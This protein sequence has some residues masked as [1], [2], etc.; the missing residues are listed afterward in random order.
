MK[1]V[2][3]FIICIVF[4]A[5]ALAG[6]S[7]GMNVQDARK[8]VVRVVQMA[9]IDGYLLENGVPVGKSIGTI[10]ESSVVSFGTGFGV[11]KAGE[12][13]QY[14]ATNQHVVQENKI[15][16][17]G[18]LKDGTPICGVTVRTG[19]YLLLDDHS[20]DSENGLDTS[21]AVPCDVIYEA[22]E[23]E[24]DLA[25]LKASEPVEQRIALP[26]LD[27]AAI[28]QGTEVRALG[29]PG[30]SDNFTAY[31]YERQINKLPSSLD[32]MTVTNGAV[33]KIAYVE[34]LN[35][36]LIQSTAQ[37]NHGNSGGPLITTDGAVIG[38]NTYGYL[39]DGGNL[40]YAVSSAHLISALDSKHIPYEAYRPGQNIPL[41][42]VIAGVAVLAVIIIAVVVVGRSKK[43]APQPGPQPTP[44]PTP[45]PVP[46]PRPAAADTAPRIQAVSG[47]LAGKRYSIEGEVSIGRDPGR[48]QIVFPQDTH[49]VSGAHCQLKVVNGV[50]YLTDL[51]STYGTYLAG[52]QRLASTQSVPLKH[53]DRF[54]LGSEREMFQVTGKGGV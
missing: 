44:Q 32:S 13:T 33:S 14:F 2:I 26:L 42:A 38:V 22:G 27:P 10:R 7:N 23:N 41:I 3:A 37:I 11:G 28:P 30:S 19:M 36:S 24:A 21:R 9:R 31:D 51:G 52:G 8:G 20:Y 1:R 17:E 6:C 43:P 16:Y 49:G 35:A 18:T 29:F 54:Y 48:S 34:R 39:D 50:L 47:A 5:T 15:V 45:Q 46:V 12:P 4:I 53:G 40:Y 25:I